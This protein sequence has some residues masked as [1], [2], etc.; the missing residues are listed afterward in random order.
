MPITENEAC[1][2]ILDGS[3]PGNYLDNPPMLRN[4]YSAE[5]ESE[6]TRCAP[7]GQSRLARLIRLWFSFQREQIRRGTEPT[8]TTLSG[9]MRKFVISYTPIGGEATGR[10]LVVEAQSAYDAELIVKDHLRD[11]GDPVNCYEVKPY[12]PPPHGWIVSPG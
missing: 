2:A 6:F 1:M 4:D 10:H 8:S 5:M 11:L 7:E 9:P 3:H 12:T